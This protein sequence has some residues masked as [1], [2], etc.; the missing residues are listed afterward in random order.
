MPDPLLTRLRQESAL[1]HTQLEDQV[2]IPERIGNLDKYRDLLEKF[3]GF[4][5]PLE[6]QTLHYDEW[7]NLGIDAKSRQKEEWLRHDLMA[8]GLSEAEVTSLPVCEQLPDCSSFARAI[9]CTY[10]LEGSTLGGRHIAGMLDKSEVPSAAR[11]FYEGYGSETGSKWKEFCAALANFGVSS[12]STDE[13]VVAATET[14]QCLGV[15]L[16]KGGQS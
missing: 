10:V 6:A 3:Y 2:N 13:T 16:S 7:E 8:L 15:W 11:R 4:Y 12:P 5:V 14:F 9:G 1:A